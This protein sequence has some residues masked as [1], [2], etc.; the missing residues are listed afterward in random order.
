MLEPLAAVTPS[1]SYFLHQDCGEDCLAVALCSKSLDMKYI[2]ASRVQVL[3]N[4]VAANTTG[5]AALTALSDRIVVEAKKL[6]ERMGSKS[7]KK[8]QA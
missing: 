8:M 7:G 2:L 1:S 6:E 3:R 5:E 4:L